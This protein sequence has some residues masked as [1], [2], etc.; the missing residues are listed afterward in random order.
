MVVKWFG[1]V[2]ENHCCQIVSVNGAISLVTSVMSMPVKTIP[3]LFRPAFG[4]LYLG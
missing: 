4:V 1:L 2:Q 3:E